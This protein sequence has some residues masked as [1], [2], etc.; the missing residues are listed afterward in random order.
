MNPPMLVWT[1]GKELEIGGTRGLFWRAD[2]RDIVRQKTN[3]KAKK[4]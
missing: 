4:I 2:S 1:R 3:K